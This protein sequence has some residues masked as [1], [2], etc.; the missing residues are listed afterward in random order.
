MQGVLPT[1]EY[2]F[3]VWYD[4]KNDDKVV[5]LVNSIRRVSS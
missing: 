3:R 4:E 2:P 5:W 1:T